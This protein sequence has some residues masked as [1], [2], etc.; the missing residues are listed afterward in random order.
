VESVDGQDEPTEFVRVAANGTFTLLHVA[1]GRYR[2]NVASG[3]GTAPSWSVRGVSLSGRDLSDEILAV[4]PGVS[5]TGVRVQLGAPRAR[6][7]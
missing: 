4:S 1:A 3:D 2:F 5:V 7:N 6:V